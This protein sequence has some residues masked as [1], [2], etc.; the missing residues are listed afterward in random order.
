[1]LLDTGSDVSIV[2]LGTAERLGLDLGEI[3][4]L[5]SIGVDIPGYRTFADLAV[6]GFPEPVPQVRLP[7][8]VPVNPEL[9]PFPVLGRDGFLQTFDVR[10]EMGPVPSA[11][12]FSVS[13]HT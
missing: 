9:P 2:R 7:V 12:R 10:L 11:G 5:A 3:D 1:M 6:G 13:P 4:V 8:F